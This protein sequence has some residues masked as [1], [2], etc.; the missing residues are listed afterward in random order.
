MNLA[1]EIIRLATLKKRITTAEIAEKYKVSRQYAHMIIRKLT[2]EKKL[3]KIGSTRSAI[4]ILPG[5]IDLISNTVKK[6]LRNK[7]LEEHKVLAD[8]EEESSV[9]HRTSDDLKSIYQY[10]FS[11][12]L[13]NAIEHSKSANIE[14]DIG[15]RN[16]DLIFHVNDFGIGVFRNVM[17]KRKLNSELEAIQD[18]L[19]GKTTTQPQSHSGEGI[20]F[21]SKTAD[22][23]ILES[24]GYS[25]TIE[26]R[27]Q[28]IFVEEIKS[29]SKGTKVTF[30]ISMKSK[31]HLNDVF[32]K[33]QTDPEALTFDK[34]EIQ[35]RLY[36]MGT[37]HISRSQ[38]RRV[39][40][41]LEKFNIIT[42]DFDKVP[43]VG[44]AFCDEIF[45]VFRNKHP[46]IQIIPINMNGAVNFMV[47][48][49]IV[50]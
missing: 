9:L 39:M 7:G 14:V 30:I 13:N 4:Y 40:T 45:R 37:I 46:N 12:M 44:Q 29:K 35:I 26:N 1:N 42:L 25:L 27:A 36:T 24:F 31:K 41:G 49:A 20:F 48:R 23:F 2:D 50:T 28:D 15:E 8:L 18:L 17:Q 3:L 47:K 6:R 21:T 16:G 34:T 11:E 32:R 22:I 19:K 33:Y 5:Y 43:T 38:A 10:T